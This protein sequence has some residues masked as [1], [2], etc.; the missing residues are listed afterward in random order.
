MALTGVSGPAAIVLG[1][2]LALS[3]T[4]VAM[5]V[6]L[7][8][9]PGP[10]CAATAALLHIFQGW[11]RQSLCLPSRRP[12]WGSAKCCLWQACSHW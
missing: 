1:G 2:G 11:F 4:A 6:L 10:H 7:Q 8:F 12:V 3:S 5:Q 9:G